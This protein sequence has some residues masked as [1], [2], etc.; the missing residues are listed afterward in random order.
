MRTSNKTW[1]GDTLAW[2]RQKQKQT[3]SLLLKVWI[4]K[5]K[6]SVLDLVKSLTEGLEATKTSHALVLH[7]FTQ[8]SY[9]L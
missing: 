6:V 2:Q 3:D 7:F 8:Q 5:Q 9:M 4:I 1:K